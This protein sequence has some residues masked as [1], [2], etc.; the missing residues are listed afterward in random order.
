MRC[1][2]SVPVC[3]IVLFKRADQEISAEE[4]ENLVYRLPGVSSV[5]VRRWTE[6]GL[7]VL[8]DDV[9][10]T[11]PQVC[12]VMQSAPADMASDE[13]YALS[14]ASGRDEAEQAESE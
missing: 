13:A 6:M 11:V 14:V 8:A 3:G 7:R 10:H 1:D 5:V 4:V 12:Q 9:D 2:C